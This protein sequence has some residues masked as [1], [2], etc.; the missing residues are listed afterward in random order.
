MNTLSIDEVKDEAGGVKITENSG[1]RLSFTWNAGAAYRTLSLYTANGQ[2]VARRRLAQDDT[3]A[4][5]VNL[6]K[7]VYLY[8]FTAGGQTKAAGKVLVE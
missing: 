1:G 2:L 5:F 7:G 8:Y 3:E 4:A 6:Q